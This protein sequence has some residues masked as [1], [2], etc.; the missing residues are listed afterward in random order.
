MGGALLRRGLSDGA[1][2]HHH[3]QFG[4]FVAQQRR[5][6]LPHAI[7]AD[8]QPVYDYREYGQRWWRR[9]LGFRLFLAPFSRCVIADNWVELQGGGLG[10]TY[11]SSPTF[12]NCLIRSNSAEVGG[13]L[14]SSPHSTPTLTNC[15]ISENRADGPWPAGSG[16]GSTGPSA[17]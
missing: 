6:D 7:R 16:A 12:I 17:R 3:R 1:Q 8:I 11:D 10:S 15:V 2:L 5:R 4:P 13:G 14:A 9:R